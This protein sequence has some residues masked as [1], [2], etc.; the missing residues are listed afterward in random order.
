[1]PFSSVPPRSRNRWAAPCA[2]AFS[3][4]E[5]LIVIAIIG[6]LVALALPTFATAREQA[7]KSS[8]ASN[9]RQFAI[10]CI[11][12]DLDFKQLPSSDS[13]S[14]TCHSFSDAMYRT[15]T[16]N[17]NLAPRFYACP[18]SIDEGTD[19]WVASNAHM[20]YTYFGGTAAQGVASFNGWALARW[21]GRAYGY[22]PHISLVKPNFRSAAMR[23]YFLDFA[24]NTPHPNAST[25]L[26]TY[27]P[28]RS[29]HT[30]SGSATAHGTNVLFLDGHVAYHTLRPGVSWALGNDAYYSFFW[31]PG[32][33]PSPYP[34][35]VT[36]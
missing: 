10:S 14:E 13:T 18:S 4:L 25:T 34:G 2:P 6:V 11:A 26:R 12:Y 3:L 15:L 8:C 5:L 33:Q 28:K 20:A 29:N 19:D 23:T 16:E 32:D 36:F 17:Y 31:D 21:P 27:Y 7:R 22:F 1:M 30:A 24:F 35:A 9:Q